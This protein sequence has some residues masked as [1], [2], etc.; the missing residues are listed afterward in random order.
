MDGK[1]NHMDDKPLFKQALVDLKEYCSTLTPE[2]IKIVEMTEFDWERYPNQFT[3][4]S[5]AEATAFCKKLLNELKEQ[6]VEHQED[7]K[8]KQAGITVYNV[9]ARYNQL[10]D[11]WKAFIRKAFEEKSDEKLF[12]GISELASNEESKDELNEVLDRLHKMIS[13]IQVAEGVAATLANK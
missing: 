4:Y 9:L 12:A 3:K 11:T 8:R 7:E 5:D 13:D 6:Y 1:K 2:E 10:S